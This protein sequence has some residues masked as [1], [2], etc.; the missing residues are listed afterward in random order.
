M[1]NC[2]YKIP[3]EVFQCKNGRNKGRFYFKCV[4]YNMGEWLEDVSPFNFGNDTCDFFQWAEKPKKINS[5]SQAYK[6]PISLNE[7]LIQ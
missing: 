7:F 6:P 4:K 2:K 3:A 5:S 1:C